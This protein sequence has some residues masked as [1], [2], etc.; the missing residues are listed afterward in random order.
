MEQ[1]LIVAAVEYFL[2]STQ[3]SVFPSTEPSL[4]TRVPGRGM[5]LF[6]C[7]CSPFK[8]EKVTGAPK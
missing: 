1:L 7:L 8:D 2:S 3:A 5:I 6:S 4:P